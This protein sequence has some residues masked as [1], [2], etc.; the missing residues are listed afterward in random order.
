MWLVF[1]GVREGMQTERCAEGAAPC[2]QKVRR[3][4][5][6]QGV[7]IHPRAPEERHFW[8]PPLLP[9]HL[10]SITLSEGGQKQVTDDE[11]SQTEESGHG[12]AI[13]GRC[14]ARRA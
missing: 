12:Q 3:A 6:E 7:V 14:Q 5:A 10:A 8:M 13:S 11:A 4:E 1:G 2:G 9:S